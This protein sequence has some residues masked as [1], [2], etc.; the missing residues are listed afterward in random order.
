MA[1]SPEQPV[2]PEKLE[3]GIENDSA[4]KREGKQNKAVRDA[5]RYAKVEPFKKGREEGEELAPPSG[6]NTNKQAES[7]LPPKPNEIQIQSKNQDILDAKKAEF[8]LDDIRTR[9]EGDPKIG[10]N[11]KQ[12]ANLSIHLGNQKRDGKITMDEHQDLIK[13]IRNSTEI[14]SGKSLPKERYEAEKNANDNVLE[15]TEDMVIPSKK[16]KESFC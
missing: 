8:I 4:R 11:E 9:K 3:K 15:L 6:D 13:L 16:E 12:R 14:Q 7:Y 2:D 1:L 10:L 5:L